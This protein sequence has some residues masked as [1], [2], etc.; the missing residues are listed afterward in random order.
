MISPSQ[1]YLQHDKIKYWTGTYSFLGI[2]WSKPLAVALPKTYQ[3]VDPQ[4]VVLC[5]Y[6]TG[7]LTFNG[8]ATITVTVVNSLDHKVFT[9]L[10]REA[11]PSEYAR[12]SSPVEIIFSYF[13]EKYVY[14]RE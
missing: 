9:T 10:V 11:I 3:G 12:F 6:P 4:S 8:T 5:V 2:S 14:A 7:A 1:G 13:K